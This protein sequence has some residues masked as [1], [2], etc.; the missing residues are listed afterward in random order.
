[1]G[2]YGSGYAS[3][4]D[5]CEDSNEASGFTSD[6]KLIDKWKTISISCGVFVP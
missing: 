4:L 5:F 2:Y 1:M 3:M 6:G